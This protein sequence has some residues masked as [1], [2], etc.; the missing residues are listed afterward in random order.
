MHNNLAT[1]TNL[2]R[3]KCKLTAKICFHFDFLNTICIKMVKRCY[4][5]TPIL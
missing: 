3:A 1:K 2:S 4:K 5:T